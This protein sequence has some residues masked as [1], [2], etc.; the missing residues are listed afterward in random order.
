MDNYDY[1][2]KAR[3]ITLDL[4][5]N[6]FVDEADK[7]FD[8]LASGSTATEILMMLRWELQS[9]INIRKNIDEGI[10]DKI[11]DLVNKIDIVLK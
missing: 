9:I 1:Y 8:A 2:E 7:I 10:L 5:K 3:E 11:V 4:K 6:G